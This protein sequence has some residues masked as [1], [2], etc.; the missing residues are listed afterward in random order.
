MALLRS[1]EWLVAAALALPL[2][3][4]AQT[5]GR[6]ILCCDDA[7]G[8]PV[9]GDVLPPVCYGRAYREISPQGT[10]RRH[11]AAPLTRQE[12]A[13]RDAEE[14]RRKEEEARRLKQRRLDE[15]LLETYKSLE[16]IDVRQERALAE[17]ER[18]LE[19]LRAREAELLA[20]RTEVEAEM[21]FYRERDVPRAL[22][23]RMRDVESELVSQ[24]SVLEAK[25][26]EKDAI[27]ARFAADRRRYAELIAAGDERR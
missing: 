10:V 18:S 25:K 12:I 26:R 17:V 1:I 23:N 15:A 6:S 19:G 2:A 22:V 14:Q 7:N 13:R 4:V 21:E 20:Q 8:R 5:G 16:D 9:C 27:H 24:R 11:V 3:A